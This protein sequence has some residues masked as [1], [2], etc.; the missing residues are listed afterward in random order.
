MIIANK[1]PNSWFQPVS[2]TI[3]SSILWGEKAPHTKN[4]YVAFDYIVTFRKRG[5]CILEPV[6]IFVSW[7]WVSLSF[8]SVSASV[9]TGIHH[10]GSHFQNICC[11]SNLPISGGAR[12]PAGPAQ[13][14]QWNRGCHQENV[15]V[16]NYMAHKFSLNSITKHLD[17]AF[18]NMTLSQKKHV[19]CSKKKLDQFIH[20]SFESLLVRK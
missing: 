16:W 14:L 11:S 15:E 18:T 9:S 12:S 4:D 10:H 17:I 6:M 8:L 20:N 19:S 3:N 2:W 5:L 1:I 7:M 13:Q